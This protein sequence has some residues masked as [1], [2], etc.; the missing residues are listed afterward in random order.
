MKLPTRPVAFAF[1]FA[2]AVAVGGCGGSTGGGVSATARARLT[3]LVQEVR[4]AANSGDRQAA[5]QALANLQGVVSSYES[6]GDI[7]SARAAQILAA[8]AG[9]ESHLG[10]IPTTTTTTAAPPRDGR[11]HGGNGP[12]NSNKGDKGNGGGE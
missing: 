1:A 4:R 9:V 5:Q 11:G 8:A 2:V 10:L 7:G 6:H 3:T 12:G